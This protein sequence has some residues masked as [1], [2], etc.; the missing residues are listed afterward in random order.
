MRDGVDESDTVLVSKRPPARPRSNRRLLIGSA[1]AV[2]VA[3]MIAAGVRYGAPIDASAHVVSAGAF[4]VALKG[5]GTLNALRKTTLS[6]TVQA[7]LRE[8]RVDVGDVVR[9]DEVVA[10]F[11]DHGAQVDLAKAILQTRT[12]AHQIEEATAQLRRE[13]ALFAGAAREFARRRTLHARDVASEGVLDVA[14]A[15]RDAASARV[16]EAQARV[17][18]LLAEF[19]VAHATV[20]LRREAFEQT[21]ITAPFDGVVLSKSHEIGDVVAP[22]AAIVELVDPCSLMV[23]ARFDESQMAGLRE[24]QVATVTFASEADRAHTAVVRRINPEVDPETREFTVDLALGSLPMNWALG[25]RAA[26]EI[27]IA[28]TPDAVAVPATFLKRRNGA[29]GVWVL[30]NGRAAWR[31]VT[32]G[33]TSGGRIHVTSGLEEG[34]TVLTGDTLYRGVRVEIR[35]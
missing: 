29:F 7:R 6:T 18:R 12:S 11:E 19:D 27:G 31:P 20:E 35:P 3:L 9:A 16:L 22:G 24:G 32:P 28:T 23:G 13:E 26:A 21:V 33:A 25:Q 14:R 30:R 17:G 15:D 1:A 8:V 10:R 2:C 5:P 34:E 4:H